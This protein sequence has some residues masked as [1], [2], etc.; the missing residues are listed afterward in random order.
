MEGSIARSLRVW[1]GYSDGGTPIRV[2]PSLYPCFM[3]L[4]Y[5]ETPSAIPSITCHMALK[6]AQS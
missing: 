5:Q 4:D 3:V 1:D 6:V 2:P